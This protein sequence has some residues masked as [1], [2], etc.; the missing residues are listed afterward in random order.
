MPETIISAL[1]AIHN[2]LFISGSSLLFGQPSPAAIYLLMQP[3]TYCTKKSHHTLD[4]IG[5]LPVFV[6]NT[7]TFVFIPCTRI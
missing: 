4:I 5:V 6:N 1:S 7:K 3:H 2:F